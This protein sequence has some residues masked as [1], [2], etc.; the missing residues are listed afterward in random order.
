MSQGISFAFH[1]KTVLVTGGSRGLGKAISLAFGQAGATVLVASRKLSAC[2]EVAD[3]IRAKGGKAHSFSANVSTWS[4]VEQLLDDVW[5]KVPFID[6]LI[7]NAGGGPIA[8]TSADATE[9]I[10]DKTIGLN[11]KGPFRLSALV[12]EK[13]LAGGG[14]SI[15][16]ISS[17]GAQKPRPWYGI[18]AAAKAGLN[19]ITVAHAFEFGPTVRVNTIS[20]GP[21]R[22]DLLGANAAPELHRSLPPQRVADPQED[23][24]GGTVSR[25][26]CRKFYDRRASSRGWRNGSQLASHLSTQ[27]IIV[28]IENGSTQQASLRTPSAA[29]GAGILVEGGLAHQ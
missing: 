6:V 19:A 25:E 14:G 9:A 28:R 18:Y 26:R 29:T 17:S 21:F 15:I 13:M 3:E 8:P 5:T 24:D 1:G 4:G 23:R 27:P 20:P 16:N 12:G 11:L 2:E 22:T 10:F 7:N